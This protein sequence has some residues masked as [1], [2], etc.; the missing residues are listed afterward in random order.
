MK[1]IGF[2]DLKFTR[3]E[4]ISLES[5][6]TMGRFLELLA[7]NFAG[8]DEFHLYCTVDL[9]RLRRGEMVCFLILEHH[10]MV[11]VLFRPTV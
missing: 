1:F 3:L 11:T 4:N 6:N 7:I 2:L 5:R 10:L 8:F 9:W